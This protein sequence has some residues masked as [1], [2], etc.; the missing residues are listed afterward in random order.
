MN[1]EDDISHIAP[2]QQADSM[3]TKKPRVTKGLRDNSRK[4]DLTDNYSF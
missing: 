1:S 3:L 4:T 2:L